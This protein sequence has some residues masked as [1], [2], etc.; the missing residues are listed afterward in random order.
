MRSLPAAL[1]FLTRF[2]V[3]RWV[4]F[5]AAGVARSAGWFPW[6]GILLGA[7]YGAAAALLRDRLPLPIPSIVLVALDALLTG[8]L[9]WDGLAD[10]PD[11]FGGGKDRED[12]LAIMRDSRIGSY[13]GV[14]LVLLIALKMAAYSLLLGH[15]HWFE[16]IL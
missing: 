11:G 6:I 4:Q 7:I 9:H 5:D 16:I 3:G 13:G 2:P 1:S 14:A 10:N 12:V 15:E 8:A